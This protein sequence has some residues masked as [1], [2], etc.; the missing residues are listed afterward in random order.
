MSDTITDDPNAPWESFSKFKELPDKIAG[1]FRDYREDFSKELS[2]L[3]ITRPHDACVLIEMNILDDARSNTD[4]AGIVSNSL[5]ENAKAKYTG[6]N[7]AT[8]FIVRVYLELGNL[9]LIRKA[10]HRYGTIKP[11]GY[12]FYTPAYR[13]SIEASPVYPDNA[14]LNWAEG[15]LE[16]DFEHFLDEKLCDISV[17]EL[18]GN[19]YFDIVHGGAGEQGERIND[20]SEREDYAMQRP[21]YDTLVFNPRTGDLMTHLQTNRRHISACYLHVLSQIIFNEEDYWTKSDRFILG[22]FAK[23]IEKLKSDVLNLGILRDKNPRLQRISLLSLT[24]KAEYAPTAEIGHSRTA[25]RKLSDSYCLT[26]GRQ[27]EDVLPEKNEK[28]D[29]ATLG[30]EFADYK[31]K[32]CRNTLTLRSDQRT[33]KGK[34]KIEG[35]DEWLREN[36]LSLIG[37]TLEERRERF[38]KEPKLEQRRP[39]KRG[40][41]KNRPI[42]FERKMSS[43]KRKTPNEDD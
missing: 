3:K 18:E 36:G 20:K 8:D 7:S 38:K 5:P 31:G 26:A 41:H 28:I 17:I 24:M 16:K 40:W 13:K 9:D 22:H 12:I 1:D 33:P 15:V 27:P 32:T 23:P 34:I 39:A 19:W 29:S 21:E 25:T 14:K 10:L 42:L 35:L 43:H 2:L 4:I 11:K 30:F 37:L 6:S